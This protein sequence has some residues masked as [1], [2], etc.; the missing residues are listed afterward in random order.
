MRGVGAEG[1]R[2]WCGNS[3]P[4]ARRQTHRKRKM[5][6]RRATRKSGRSSKGGGRR[7]TGKQSKRQRKRS[8]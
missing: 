2:V 7:R 4:H 5:D 8:K 1:S 3:C 6:K